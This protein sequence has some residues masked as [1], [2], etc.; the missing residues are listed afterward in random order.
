MGRLNIVKM[1]AIS[2]MIYRFNTIP[3][4]IP[5]SHY[6]DIDKLTLKFVLFCVTQVHEDIHGNAVY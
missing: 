6:M 4:K 1:S 2:N 3:T 5:A